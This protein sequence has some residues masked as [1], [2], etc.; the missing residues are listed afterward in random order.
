MIPNHDTYFLLAR[1]FIYDQIQLK[2]P[3]FTFRAEFHSPK[4]EF[5]ICRQFN[6][7]FAAECKL[8]SI[9]R[10]IN[11]D[12]S[13]IILTRLDQIHL[14]I[15]NSPWNPN[16]ASSVSSA[17]LLHLDLAQCGRIYLSCRYKYQSK[18]EISDSAYEYQQIPVY[19]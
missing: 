5:G 18:E 4:S 12:S 17:V 7:E 1:K 11:R 16:L 9:C 14:D 10:K 6:T 13:S 19:Y 15:E 8:I 2:L 3:N